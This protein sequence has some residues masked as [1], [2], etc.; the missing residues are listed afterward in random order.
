M[1]PALEH[2]RNSNHEQEDGTNRERLEPHTGSPSMTAW[3]NTFLRA[4]VAITVTRDGDQVE[5]RLQKTRN[6]GEWF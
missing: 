1:A 5:H 2:S 4:S 6:V 3:R